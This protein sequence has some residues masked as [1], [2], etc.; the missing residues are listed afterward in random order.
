[1]SVKIAMLNEFPE[2]A[3]VLAYWTYHE[4]YRKRNIDFRLVLK[5]YQARL[6]N[7]TP[8]LSFLVLYDSFPVGMVSLKE[9]DIISR[10]DLCPWLSSLYVIPEYRGRG[11]GSSLIATLT[12]RA[13]DL[14]FNSLYLFLGNSNQEYLENLYQKKGWLYLTDTMDNDGC[15]TKIFFRNL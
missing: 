8:P 14:G 13:R 1:M 4:W 11:I 9:H 6:K 5:S 12:D 7:I 3:P 15:D 10:K 2:Y